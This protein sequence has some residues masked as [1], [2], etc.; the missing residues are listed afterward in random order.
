M[1]NVL[2]IGGKGTASV[3]AD[4]LIHANK[5]GHNEYKFCGFVNDFE[6]YIDNHPVVG[7]LYDIQKLVKEGYFFIYTLNKIGGQE[8]RTNLF[9]SLGIPE[10]R[11]C[12]FIHPDAYVASSVKLGSGCVVLANAS[13]SSQTK[14]GNCSLI[15]NN[16]SIGHDNN[17]GEFNFFT[18]NSCLGSYI[19]TGKSCWFGLNCTVRGKLSIGKQST[20]GIGSVVT[21]NIGDNEIWIG[22]PAKF[23]KKNTSDVN[24]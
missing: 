23:H 24:M 16:V 19:N 15:M 3:I 8:E 21:K 11:L 4:N 20:I 2:I 18:A 12:T 5:L 7:K 14:I 22:N 1:K 13:I 9:E 6:E 10:E 17:I